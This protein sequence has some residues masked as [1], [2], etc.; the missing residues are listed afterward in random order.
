VKDS[1][2]AI[3]SDLRKIKDAQPQLSSE[4]KEEVQ[5]ANDEFVSEFNSVVAGLPTDL[6]ISGAKAKLSAATQQLAA[7]YRSAYAKVNC[8]S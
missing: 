3:K 4:R 6:S 7:A 2:N 1:L 5:S 8:S